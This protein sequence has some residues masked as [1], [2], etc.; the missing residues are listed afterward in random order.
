MET[1]LKIHYVSPVVK[2][3]IIRQES[4]ICDSQ[5]EAVRQA[6]DIEEW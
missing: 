5:P 3:L 1:K 4:F 2:T 6:Y